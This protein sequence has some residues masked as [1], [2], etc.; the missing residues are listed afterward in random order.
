MSWGE[1]IRL[2]GVLLTDPTS[3]VFA[4]RNDWSG[5]RSPEWFLL[6]DLFDLTHRAHAKN[7][8]PYPRPQPEHRPARRGGTTMSRAEV[9]A[10][11]NRYGH[12]FKEV[13]R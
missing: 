13:Q 5:P 11:L 3:Q 10:V 8:P 2:T 7:P 1:A 4:A 9:L 6:A 12:D